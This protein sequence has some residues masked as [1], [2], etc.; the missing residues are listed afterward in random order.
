M[1]SVDHVRLQLLVRKDARHPRGVA[2]LEAALRALGFDVTGAGRATVSARAP[3]EVFDAVFGGAPP[4]SS[5][6]G[7]AAADAALPVP[8]SLAAYVESVSL[9]PRHTIISRRGRA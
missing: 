3:R 9:A 7:S 2:G 6:R 5:F 8:P 1:P 4:P